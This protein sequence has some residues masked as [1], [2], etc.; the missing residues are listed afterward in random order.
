M[1]GSGLIQV[2][3]DQLQTVAGQF[4]TESSNLQ[5]IYNLL[6]SNVAILEESW[7]GTAAVKFFNDMQ[8]MMPNFLKLIQSLDIASQQVGAISR[9]WD[10]AQNN[11]AGKLGHG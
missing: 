7:S 6:N 10:D 11:A 5:S 4:A 1:A 9:H 2:D 8:I 3:P